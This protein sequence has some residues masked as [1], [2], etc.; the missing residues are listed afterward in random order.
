MVSGAQTSETIDSQNDNTL[1]GNYSQPCRKPVGRPPRASVNPSVVGKEF[2]AFCKG[3]FPHLNLWLSELPD[4]RRQELCKYTASHIWHHI[5]MTFLTRCGSRNAYDN[6]RNIGRGPANVGIICGQEENDFRFGPNGATVTCSDNAAHHSNRVEPEKVVEIPEKML[7]ELFKRRT[8]DNC[9]IFNSWYVMLADGSVREKCRKG[10]EQGGKISKNA[11]GEICRYYYVLQLGILGPDGILLPFAHESID[12]HD[13]VADKEDCELKAFTRLA[14][15]V[16]KEFPRTPFCIVADSLYAVQNVVDICE[17]NGWKYVFTLKE[18]R[19]PSL[20][21]EA[22]E[23]LPFVSGNRARI[24]RDP[25][26]KQEICDF[27]W[28][29]KLSIGKTHFCNLILCGDITA[30]SA[31][32]YAWITNFGNLTPTRVVAIAQTAG[33][34]RHRIEDHFNTQKNNGA[35][36]E[37]VFCANPWGGK[38]YYTMLQVAETLWQL[39]YRGHLLRLYEWA[40]KTTQKGL[41]IILGENLRNTLLPPEIKPIGQLRFIT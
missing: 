2:A 31:I 6:V 27:R 30:D 25:Q 34:K 7:R 5:I 9:R 39:F 41:A 14:A 20:W 36:L 10:F 28:I 21:E 15:R 37:H 26:K 12:M 11:S 29:E 38:N 16:K 24:I 35:G 33:R 13:P 3:T 22:V 32:L 40:R 8:L 1:P 4:P 17:T 19:Q 18:G 23:L